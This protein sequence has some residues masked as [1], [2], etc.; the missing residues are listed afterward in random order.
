MYA[1][2]HD[3]LNKASVQR[4]SS[5]LTACFTQANVWAMCGVSLWWFITF[6]SKIS[7]IH[8]DHGTEF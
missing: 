6:S 7:S 2:R 5:P 4:S 3:R 8:S 1:V